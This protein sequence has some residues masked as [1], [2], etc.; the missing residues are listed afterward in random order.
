LERAAL[1]AR[2]ILVDGASGVPSQRSGATAGWRSDAGGDPAPYRVSDTEPPLSEM[3]PLS[4]SPPLSVA[5][6]LSESPP[7]SEMPPLSE[8]QALSESPP[9]IP[10]VSEPPSLV[11]AMPEASVP[12]TPLSEAPPAPRTDETL[13]ALP[14]E[15]PP[16]EPPPFEPV[17]A[18]AAVAE[19]V[20]PPA[21]IA[22]I[23]AEGA[24]APDA[25]SAEEATWPAE[26]VWT[27]EAV[28]ASAEL[29]APEEPAADLEV[30]ALADVPANGD[31]PASADRPTSAAMPASATL[32]PLAARAWVVVL[33]R[34]GEP[35]VVWHLDRELFDFYRVSHADAVIE[36]RVVGVV[37]SWDGVE[38][39]ELDLPVEAASG[40]QALPSLAGTP[41][42]RAALGVRVSGGAAAS[43]SF[44][45]LVVGIEALGDGVTFRP[46]GVTAQFAQRAL[47]DARST[48][49]S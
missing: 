7:L 43:K 9:E 1:G 35:C 19:A 16:F 42:I 34:D 49:H 33:R 23:A 4:E 38:R 41:W 39:H 17:P 27:P 10:P 12:V 44:R 47:E 8:A 13:E 6:P 22:P 46:Y 2:L 18:V 11:A 37:S 40:R 31:L 14:F 32:L 30:P 36:L 45:P 48:P 5:R 24:L 20:A 26:V 28:P 3:P 25:G 21:L 29:W 15:P